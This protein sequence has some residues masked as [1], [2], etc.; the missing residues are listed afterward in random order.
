MCPSCGTAS[1]L[2]P[3]EGEVC[4]WPTGALSSFLLALA[5]QSSVPQQ[6]GDRPAAPPGTPCA[7]TLCHPAWSSSTQSQPS[8]VGWATTLGHHPVPPSP[9]QQH[10]E[11][12]QPSELVPRAPGWQAG[13]AAAVAAVPARCATAAR[14]GLGAAHSSSAKAIHPL[15]STIC[16]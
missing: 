11:P 10:P 2:Q 15:C 9:V 1:A 6:G 5:L 14:L 13:V 4:S 12:A 8:M 16:H 7:T 3:S